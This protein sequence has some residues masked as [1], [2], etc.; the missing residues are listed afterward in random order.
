ME[1]L[2]SPDGLVF[3]EAVGIANEIIVQTEVTAVVGA[4]EIPEK[5]FV[6]GDAA[7]NCTIVDAPGGDD[8][9]ELGA[10][11][12]I[13]EDNDE[14]TLDVDFGESTAEVEDSGRNVEMGEEDNSVELG[15]AR[16]IIDVDGINPCAVLAGI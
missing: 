12:M 5:I 10:E 9:D 14:S 3:A 1:K 6:V 2:N 4:L 11:T 13:R 8:G 7:D 16:T 15:D